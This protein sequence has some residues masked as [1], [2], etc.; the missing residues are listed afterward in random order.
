MTGEQGLIWEDRRYQL[1]CW[2]LTEK[3]QIRS[4]QSIADAHTARSGACSCQ[5]AGFLSV[6]FPAVKLVVVV[7]PW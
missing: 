6:P 7:G 3:D 4:D 1:G 5:L 2:S